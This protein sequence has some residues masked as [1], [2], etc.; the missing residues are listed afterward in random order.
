MSNEIPNDFFGISDYLKKIG[1]AFN[2]SLE[3]AT[4]QRE[5]KTRRFYLMSPGSTEIRHSGIVFPDGEV[6]VYS[7]AMENVQIFRSLD[8]YT[9]RYRLSQV[10][11]VDPEPQGWHFDPDE[12]TS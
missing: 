12:A 1:D 11:W 10:R 4:R 7:H 2:E 9:D 5:C 6:A 3:Q 8:A